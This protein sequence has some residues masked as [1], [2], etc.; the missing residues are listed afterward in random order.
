MLQHASLWGFCLAGFVNVEV[1]HRV[2]QIDC[3]WVWVLFLFVCFLTGR[4]LFVAGG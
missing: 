4:A 3:A 1:V 2:T